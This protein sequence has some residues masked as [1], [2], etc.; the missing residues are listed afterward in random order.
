MPPPAGT[1]VNSTLGLLSII[2]SG[3]GVALMPLQIAQRPFAKQYLQVVP[4]A[5]GPLQLMLVALDRADAAP[6]PSVRHFLAHLHRKAHRSCES[7]VLLPV[8]SLS[9]SGIQ[10]DAEASRGGVQT[11]APSR[12]NDI[13]R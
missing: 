1:L 10:R 11:R 4:V 12:T 5:E 8:R 9:D 2:A 7:T 6:K 13:A 3:D